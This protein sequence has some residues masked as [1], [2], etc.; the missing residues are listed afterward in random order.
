MTES[1]KPSNVPK[2]APARQKEGGATER[3]VEAERS[4]NVRDTLAPERPKPAPKPD[5]ERGGKSGDAD[6][7]AP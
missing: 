2:P 6:D 3:L 5:P 7:G 1:R 4:L